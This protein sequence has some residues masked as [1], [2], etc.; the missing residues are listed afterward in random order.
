MS[1]PD[2]KSVTAD[3]VNSPPHYN[4]RPDGVECIDAIESSMSK[5]EFRAYL[6]GTIIKYVWRY[7]HKH[8][9]LTDLDKALWLSLI[10]I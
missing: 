3:L 7:D 5:Q 2:D 8:N 9:P 4:V 6:K 1:G 10:H